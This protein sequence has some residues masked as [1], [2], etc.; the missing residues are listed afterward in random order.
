[1]NDCTI[2]IAI[3]EYQ[4]GYMQGFREGYR[5]LTPSIPNQKTAFYWAGVED[6]LSLAYLFRELPANVL[7]RIRQQQEGWA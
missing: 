5:N 3:A 1:M 4:N 7:Q 6:G 2:Q